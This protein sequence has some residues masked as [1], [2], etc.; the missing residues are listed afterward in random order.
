MSELLSLVLHHL[1]PKRAVFLW[2][3]GEESTFS[4]CDFDRDG[5]WGCRRLWKFNQQDLC[6]SCRD[7][8]RPKRWSLDFFSIFCWSHFFFS[9]KKVIVFR[10]GHL[11][12]FVGA[13][14]DLGF[15]VFQCP[16]I[17]PKRLISHN[18]NWPC[19][20]VSPGKKCH[21]R[22]PFRCLRSIQSLLQF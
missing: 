20:T 13:E 8:Q 19:F 3:N 21:V 12:C 16:P 18:P 5:G 2:S 11:E 1:A 10:A 9:G 6:Q 17:C 14:Y 15:Q 4:R 22:H 7:F